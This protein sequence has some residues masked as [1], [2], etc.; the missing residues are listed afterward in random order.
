[1]KILKKDLDKIKEKCKYVTKT[2]KSNIK[3]ERKKKP[4]QKKE[5]L[6]EF[7]II[8]RMIKRAEE[9]TL[10]IL[11]QYEKN[12]TIFKEKVSIRLNIVKSVMVE[13]I[14]YL[15][16]S[17]FDTIKLEKAVNLLDKFDPDKL[18]TEIYPDEFLLN[19][20]KLTSVGL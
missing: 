5:I 20:S 19:S 14:E 2:M 10:I 16:K 1:M 4:Q 3:L 18:A 7:I 11:E 17:F 6:V 13:Y 9:H 12:W 15:K 8:M